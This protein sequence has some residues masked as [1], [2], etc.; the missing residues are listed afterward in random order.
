MEFAFAFVFGIIVGMGITVI[1][2]MRFNGG[3]LKIDHSDS[4]RDVYLFEI[5]DLDNISEKDFIILH[6][7]NYADLSQK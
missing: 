1:S 3:T 5:K 6:V 2:L 7:D 4:Q